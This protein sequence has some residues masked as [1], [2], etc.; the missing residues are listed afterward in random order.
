MDVNA[1]GV[2]AKTFSVEDKNGAFV[3]TFADLPIPGDEGAE[4]LEKRL[5]G[6]RDGMVGNIK[7]KL[8]GDKKIKLAGK[9]PGREV[10]ADLPGKKGV[11]RARIYVVGKR[12]YQVMVIGTSD[13]ANSGDATKFLESFQLTQ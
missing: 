1:A 9:Y 5:D 13:T 4:L 10:T 11:I 7:A 8:T 2:T 3:V 6:S 12:L